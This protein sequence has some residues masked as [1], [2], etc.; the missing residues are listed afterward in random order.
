MK[1]KTYLTEK[2]VRQ[3]KHDLNLDDIIQRRVTEGEIQIKRQLIKTNIRKL[4]TL[5]RE[6]NKANNAKFQA[7]IER[8]EK[9]L[10]EL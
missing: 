4:D 1:E 7:Y 5:R 10:A 6:Q 3:I 9:E 8:L 2:E